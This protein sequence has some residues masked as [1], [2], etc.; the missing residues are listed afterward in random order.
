M[1]ADF[2]EES[3]WWLSFAAEDG[4]RGVVIIGPV[5]G[6]LLAAVAWSHLLGINPGGEAAGFQFPPGAI[7]HVPETFRKR[8]LT[9]DQALS[10]DEMVARRGLA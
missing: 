6:G 10:V 8:V 7:E 1:T 4:F 3:W 5:P 2:E 9:K